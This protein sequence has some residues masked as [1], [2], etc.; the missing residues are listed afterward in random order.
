MIT[1]AVISGVFRTHVRASLF[2]ELGVKPTKMV[3]NINSKNTNIT[4][5]DYRTLS[6]ESWFYH[7]HLW[8]KCGENRSRKAGASLGV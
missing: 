6:P 1:R 2:W 5:D 4:W 3:K 8:S 7:G